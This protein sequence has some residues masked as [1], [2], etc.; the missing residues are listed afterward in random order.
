AHAIAKVKNP[1]EQGF[2]A[3]MGV[4]VDTFLVLNMTA[5][6]IFVTGALDGKTSGIALTQKAF[7]LGLGS[8]GM[9]FVAV[10]MLFFAFSTIIGW[11]FFG[12]QNIMFLF[13]E[14]G[15]TP[16]RVVV[17]LFVCLGSALK[18]DL[19][20]ELAD[21]FNGIMVFPNLLA[22]IGLS[23]VVSEAL[24]NFDDQ[25]RLKATK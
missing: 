2:V 16:Y 4:F 17:M 6:V 21:F 3:I 13:G 18:L 15:L 24:K 9:P 20:W 7:T 25:G 1:A 22:L 12:E 19:V 23:K 5:F 11:Y 8:Y 14:K 10:C